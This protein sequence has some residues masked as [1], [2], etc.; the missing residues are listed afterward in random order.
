MIPGTHIGRV[1]RG[2]P[3][4]LAGGGVLCAGPAGT[5]VVHHQSIMHRR[6][7]VTVEQPR[8][9]L[10]YNYWRTCAPRRD[11]VAEPAFDLQVR[12][13]PHSINASSASAAGG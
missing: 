2:A 12:S 3:G 1:D 9:M 10:K 13:P 4:A 7:A 8:H 6:A 11:W 5:L